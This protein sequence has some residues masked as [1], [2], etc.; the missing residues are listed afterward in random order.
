MEEEIIKVGDSV[1]HKFIG[2]NKEL[3]VAAIDGTTVTT[4]YYFEQKFYTNEFHAYELELYQH[5]GGSVGSFTF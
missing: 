4:R 5:K 3:F 1:N 2:Q